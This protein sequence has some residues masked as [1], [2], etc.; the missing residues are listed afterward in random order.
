MYA[1]YGKNDEGGGRRG[2]RERGEGRLRE[3]ELSYLVGGAVGGTRGGGGD[4]GGASSTL[5][6]SSTS[7]ASSSSSSTSISS[8]PSSSSSSS[9]SFH[10]WINDLHCSGINIRRLGGELLSFHPTHVV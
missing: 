7:L 8:S 2:A 1:V 4:S 5:A 9:S 6:F 3:D 10:S